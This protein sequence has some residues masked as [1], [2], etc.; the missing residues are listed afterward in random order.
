MIHTKTLDEVF[1][2]NRLDYKNTP[3]NLQTD[4]TYSKIN[5]TLDSKM[6]LDIPLQEPKVGEYPF[7]GRGFTGSQNIVLPEYELR[8]GAN[9]HFQHGDTIGV[10]DSKSGNLV[11][12]Y[13]YDGEFNTWMQKK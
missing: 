6:R 7:T 11:K 5:F 2:G 1:E 10:Y 12:Q 4:E 3:Y 13:I 9:Y 8:K